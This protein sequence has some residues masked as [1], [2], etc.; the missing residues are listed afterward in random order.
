MPTVPMLQ[1]ILSCVVLLGSLLSAGI[2]RTAEKPNFLFIYTDDQRWDAMGVVQREQG[3]K[4]RFPWLKTPNMDRL[5]AEGVRFRNAFVVNS[6]CAPSRAC[7]LTGR[8]SHVNGVA[9][10][11]TPF[12]AGSTT[13]ATLLRAAGY[14]T[15]YVGKWHM[16]GQKGQRPGFDFS[17]SFIGQGRYFDCPVEV[18]GQ[19]TDTKGWVDDVSTDFA[20]DFLKKN[21]ARP[22]ALVIG[23]KAC[24]GP[25]TPP[26]RAKERFAGAVAKPAPNRDASAIY[27]GAQ[28]EQPQAKA[29]QKAASSPE[30]QRAG[31]NLNYF[32]CISAADD[33]VGRLLAALDDL[34]LAENTV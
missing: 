24:H 30:A 26:D 2:A 15:G 1:K 4:A 6:L 9:N 12:P 10:N 29:K 34:G 16:D 20:I 11:H 25:F 19:P 21:R 31:V 8:Y 3:E 22:F 28:K 7:F 5:A 32:R 33:N 18:N 13:H 27:R 17:A 14:A 23:F